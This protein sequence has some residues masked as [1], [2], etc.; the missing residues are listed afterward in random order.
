MKNGEH[1]PPYRTYTSQ[2]A[3]SN[4]KSAPPSRDVTH[5]RQFKHQT[6]FATQTQTQCNLIVKRNQTG[7]ICHTPISHWLTF[8]GYVGFEYTSKYHFVPLLILSILIKKEIVCAKWSD[9]LPDKNF[10]WNTLIHYAKIE[11]LIYADS[12]KLFTYFEHWGEISSL[13]NA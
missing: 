9:R 7:R 5:D 13:L 3:V 11:Q 4:H 8:L 12:N 1:D 6:Q 10:V 2:P